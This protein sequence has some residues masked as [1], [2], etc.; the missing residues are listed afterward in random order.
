M[1]WIFQT[2][3]I[4]GLGLEAGLLARG[5][6]TGSLKRYAFFYS[7]ISY[8]LIS[9][10]ICAFVDHLS[11]ANYASLYWFFLIVRTLAEFG[12]LWAVS[13]L[14]FRPYPLP[15]VVGRLFVVTSA[16]AFILLFW[17]PQGWTSAPSAENF[18]NL[19]QLSSLTKSAAI[20]GIFL[21]VRFFQVPL[22]RNAG[23]ILLGLVTFYSIC[24]VNFAAAMKFGRPI[25]ENVISWLAPLS[26][27]FCLTIWLV[28]LWK[29]D[30]VQEMKAS[31]N[32]GIRGGGRDQAVQL[33]KLGATVTR[34]LWK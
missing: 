22:G 7:Y 33:R 6:A 2:T 12:V 23:G 29:L 21:A 27:G 31:A 26:Y 17:A 11:P 13:D 1:F 14:I 10:I 5:Y 9:E 25:Y 4:L 15:R 19:I 3:L 32:G 20:A 24:I 18:L 8:V 16:S 28:A 34:L 30:P